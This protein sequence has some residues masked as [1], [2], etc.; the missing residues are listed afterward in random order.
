MDS[1]SR[2]LV[3]AD[4]TAGA[5]QRARNRDSLFLMARLV[6]PDGRE[7][8]EVRVRNLS[9]GGLMVEWDKPL[10]DGA[11]VTLILRGVGEVTGRVA[12]CAEGRIGVA[13]DEPIDPLLARK[14]VGQ[15]TR[16]PEYAKPLLG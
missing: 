1:L 3:P 2:P 4:D 11:K 16:T 9:A 6:V 10:D 12:W 15:G 13:F 5:S 14:P 8:H 7:P